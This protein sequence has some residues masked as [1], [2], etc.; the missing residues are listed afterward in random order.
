MKKYVKKTN[1]TQGFTLIEI[2]TVLA[3][4]GILTSILIPAVSKAQSRARVTSAVAEI[5]SART[6]VVEAAARNGGTLPLTE[7]T[8]NDIGYAAT[9]FSS[10]ADRTRTGDA[11]SFN[12]GA[13]LDQ[14]LLSMN[15]AVL[16]SVF[17]SKFAPGTNNAWPATAGRL[18]W[19]SISGTWQ[20]TNPTNVANWAAT[21]SQ[22]TATRMECSVVDAAFVLANGPANGINFLLDG[23]TSLPN[24]RCAFVVYPKTPVNDARS[25]AYD[26]NSSS[27]M[28]DVNP[29]VPVA[30]T[31]GRVI[32]AAPVGGVT[33]VYVFLA[34]F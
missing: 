5:N 7:A 4:I 28:D 15:P 24:G 19:N 11:A 34:V 14:M 25:L 6:A 22:A 1:T 17:T 13:R 16:D 20:T 31:R 26:L 33:T 3:I 29:N 21:V 30:Q 18:T 23:T 8:T 12:A 32:Y 9:D 27:L 10:A 2:L